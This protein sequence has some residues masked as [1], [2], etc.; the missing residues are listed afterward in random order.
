M[1]LKRIGIIGKGK[2]GGRA[3][4]LAA[5]RYEVSVFD[6]QR[7][8][9]AAAARSDALEAIIVFVPGDSFLEILPELVESG[10]PCIVGST[11]FQFPYGEEQFDRVLKERNTAWIYGS[12]FSLGMRLIERMLD[13]LSDAPNL[14]SNHTFQLHEI[15]HIRK[16]DAPSGTALSW[17]NRLGH[18]VDISSERVGDVVGTHTLTLTTPYERIT[19]THEA[20]NRNIFADGALYA[21]DILLNNQINNGLHRFQDIVIGITERV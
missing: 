21:A 15:H 1:T 9:S 2:T 11:G 12:N 6:S 5:N 3:I 20:L 18:S 8:F 17:K 19:L 16:V 13:V 7:P 10:L 14:F 4:E